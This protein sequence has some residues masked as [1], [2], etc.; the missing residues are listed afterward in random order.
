MKTTIAFFML[1]FIVN[2]IYCQIRIKEPEFSGNIVYVND[3]IGNGISLDKQRAIMETKVNTATYIPF[4]DMVAGGAKTKYVIKECCS[5]V[6]ISKKDTLSFIVKV[7]DNSQDPESSINVF[8]D[9]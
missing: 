7:P 2:S 5:Q 1:T 4:A 8:K 3:T 9:T 6:R